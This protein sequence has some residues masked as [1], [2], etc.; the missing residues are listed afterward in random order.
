[1]YEELAA[2]VAEDDE[3]LALID[4]LPTGKRQ[5]N[6]VLAA[7]RFVADTPGCYE[8]FRRALIDEW[9][10]VGAVVLSRSTQT[11]EVGRCAS[12]V[13]LLAELPQPVALLEVGASAGLCLLL[14]HY[15]YDYGPGAQLGP[16]ESP[17]TLTREL[18]GDTAPPQRLPQVAW[19]AGL[20][21]EPVDVNDADAVR[22]LETLIW[23]G[24]AERQRRLHSAVTIARAHRPRVERGDLRTDLGRLVA[25]APRQAT[26]VVFH[27]AVLAYL[28]SEDRDRVAEQLSATDAV[29]ISNEAPGVLPAGESPEPPTDA[30]SAFLVS[31]NGR[32]TAWADPHGSWFR[33][34]PNHEPVGESCCGTG[35]AC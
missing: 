11:N 29:W 2:G 9:T 28:A 25:Q 1:M 19:R 15:R 12:L 30:T 18:R 34:L 14:D 4:S 24:Q 17:V 22:W 27:S 21:L 33:R 26:L 3:A 16:A 31:R 35:P 5:P 23:P 13:P 20:D 10:Q 7:V 8:Q 32:P 6:L